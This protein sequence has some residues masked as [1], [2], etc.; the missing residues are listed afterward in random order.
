[1]VQSN[2]ALRDAVIRLPQVPMSFVGIGCIFY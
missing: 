1:M 2:P